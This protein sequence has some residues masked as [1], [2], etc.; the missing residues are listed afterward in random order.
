MPCPCARER[1]FSGLA[2][3][4]LTGDAAPVL[5]TVGR[6]LDAEDREKSV[7]YRLHGLAELGGDLTPLVPRLRRHLAEH[8]KLVATNIAIAA[9]LWR[10]HHDPTEVLPVL[11][12]AF[13]RLGSYAPVPDGAF[14]LAVELGPH[15]EPLLPVLRKHIAKDG[16]QATLRRLGALPAN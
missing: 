14:S 15:A 4:R 13:A 8:P 5:A 6:D 7:P 16:V 12:A 2:L 11:E 10:L 1:F 3:W 9:L